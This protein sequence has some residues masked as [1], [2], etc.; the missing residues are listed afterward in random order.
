M[1][2]VE[3][4]AITVDGDLSDWGDL[5]T[6]G[7]VLQDL[8]DPQQVERLLDHDKLDHPIEY[9]FR[10]GQRTPGFGSHQEHLELKLAGGTHGPGDGNPGTEVSP[11]GINDDL[12]DR[13]S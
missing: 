2:R 6:R 11:H 9:P 10:S 13:F 12:H 8:N 4:G 1:S 7:L 5:P 3:P